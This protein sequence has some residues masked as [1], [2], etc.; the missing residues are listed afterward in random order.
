MQKALSLVL[1]LLLSG[2]G[3]YFTNV[4]LGMSKQELER[5]A[6]KPHAVIAAN[7][8]NENLVEVVEYRRGGYWWGDLD[9]S[10]WF[11]FNGNKLEKW[12]RSGD[13]LLRYLD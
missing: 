10:Y 12:G 2:C 8:V 1:V 6:G 7:R 13:H 11:F 4:K 9:Q 5:V 3:S